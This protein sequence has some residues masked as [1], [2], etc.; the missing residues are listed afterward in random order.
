MLHLFNFDKVFGQVFASENPESL[1]GHHF[2]PAEV[3]EEFRFVRFGQPGFTGI[4]NGIAVFGSRHTRQP[5]R[6]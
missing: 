2:P 5:I 1:G 6:R 4:K 3:I